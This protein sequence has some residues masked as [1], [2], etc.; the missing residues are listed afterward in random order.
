MREKIPTIRI[1][2]HSWV[3]IAVQMRKDNPIALSGYL[4]VGK[5]RRI[6]THFLDPEQRGSHS[7]GNKI[8]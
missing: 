5:V 1:R 3:L 2:I 7:K 6:I 4:P 8:V